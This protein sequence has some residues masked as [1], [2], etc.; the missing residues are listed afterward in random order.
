MQFPLSAEDVDALASASAL[1]FSSM[2]RPSVGADDS[3][4][5]EEKKSEDMVSWLSTMARDLNNKTILTRQPMPSSPAVYFWT[6]RPTNSDVVSV[7][8]TPAA[9]DP[10]TLEPVSGRLDPVILR[11]E[12]AQ[13][14]AA[15]NTVCGR[16][17][18][19][20]KGFKVSAYESP[21]ETHSMLARDEVS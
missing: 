11:T 1:Q 16:G 15:D 18:G 12:R 14:L 10:V 5:P 2:S 3:A 21:L 19:G 9:I 8:N 17:V 13:L 4:I 6:H 20:V 7:I